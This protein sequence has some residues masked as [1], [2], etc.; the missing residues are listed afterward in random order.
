MDGI[1]QIP[2]KHYEFLRNFFAEEPKWWD[3]IKNDVEAL[4]C[5]AKALK[6]VGWY[7]V[8]DKTQY[9]YIIKSITV[10]NGVEI[11]RTKL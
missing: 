8:D 10:E 7:N 5:W 9:E 11:C 4:R 3:E 6:E 2:P 1:K